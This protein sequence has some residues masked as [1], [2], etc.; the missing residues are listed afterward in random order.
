MRKLRRRFAFWFTNAFVP[1]AYRPLNPIV[2]RILDSPLHPVLSWYVAVVRFE[3][4]RT[5]KRYDVPFT[6][7]RIDERTYECTTN[8]R[9]V[10]WRN[11]IGGRDARLLFKGRWHDAHGEA[12]EDPAYLEEALRRRDPIRAWIVDVEVSE[13]VAVRV[14]LR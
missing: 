10:W 13:S 4:R 9:A 8:V 11:F 12:I 5:G 14:T 7:H 1:F 3:G 2:T 6:F